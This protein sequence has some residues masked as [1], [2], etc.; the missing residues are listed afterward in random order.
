ME[1]SG[2]RGA[3]AA[4]QVLPL[5]RRT[6]PLPSSHRQAEKAEEKKEGDGSGGESLE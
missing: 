5:E 2:T 3:V 4:E 6:L 1:L